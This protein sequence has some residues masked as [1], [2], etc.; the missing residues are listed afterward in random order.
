MQ[1]TACKLVAISQRYK[2]SNLEHDSMGY[3]IGANFDPLVLA[4]EAKRGKSPPA[5]NITF[6]GLFF[7]RSQI[8]KARSHP[9]T[10]PC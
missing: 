7:C 9:N 10:L 4:S 1:Q 5:C 6:Y 3:P 8:S 2:R